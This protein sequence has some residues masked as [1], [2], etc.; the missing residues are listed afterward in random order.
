[1]NDNQIAMQLRDKSIDQ[2]EQNS[3]TWVNEA[4]DALRTFCRSHPGLLF[5]VPGF[6]IFAEKNYGLPKAREGRAY[7]AV[8]RKA[9]KDKL[10]ES[11]DSYCPSPLP[12]Q[13]LRPVKLWRVV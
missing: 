1:M 8:I 5:T 11:T 9:L 7:G 2:V 3:L 6:S 13:H 10:I 12:W 4:Y